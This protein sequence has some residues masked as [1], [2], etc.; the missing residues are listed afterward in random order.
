MGRLDTIGLMGIDVG[1]TNCGVGI[2]YINPETLEIT[3]IDAS[4]MSI[5]NNNYQLNNRLTH[6]LRDLYNELY[7]LICNVDPITVHLEYAFI[8]RLRPGAYGPLS[9]ARGVIENCILDVNFNYD[10]TNEILFD[11]YP[12][13]IIK[14]AVGAKGGA[15]KVSIL[16]AMLNIGEISK[17]I[18]LYTLT[19]DMV[20]G[21]A[22]AYTTLLF[23]RTYPEI[24]L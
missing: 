12:P 15:N 13:S 1:T 3:D 11:G 5:I 18:D 17:H 9:Q 2:I 21:I 19:D 20:D 6:R 23:I 16:E 24:L 14:N 7:N 10:T 8:N 4:K 22:I